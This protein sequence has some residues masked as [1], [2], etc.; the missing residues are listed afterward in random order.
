MKAY[1]KV[2]TVDQ[3]LEG[4]FERLVTPPTVAQAG[5]VMAQLSQDI[6]KKLGDQWLVQ[7]AW[8]A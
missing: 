5:K 6:A 3:V 2:K 8:T 7:E 1:V 4:T